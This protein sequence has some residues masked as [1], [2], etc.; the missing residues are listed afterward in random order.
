MAEDRDREIQQLV[1][2]L[3]AAQS[4]VEPFLALHTSDAVE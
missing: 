3:Q 2:R 4:D 1:E